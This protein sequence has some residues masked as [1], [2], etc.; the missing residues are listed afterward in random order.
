M[1]S[2]GAR[3]TRRRARAE[4]DSLG[5]V[6]NL[7]RS[8]R[9]ETRQEIQSL[10]GLGRAVVA[11]RVATLIERGLV[12]EGPPGASTGGRAPTTVRM[13]ASAG[14]VL[15]GSLGTTTLGV[16]LAD[17]TGNLLIEHHEPNDATLGAERTLVR[18]TELFDWLLDEH[19]SIREAWAI[20]LAVPG[21]VGPTGGRLG[22]RPTLH[23]MP[24]WADF[25]IVDELSSRYGAPVIVDSEVHFMA[26]GELRAGQGVGRDDLVFVKV[27]T[28]ISAGLCSDGRIHRGAHGYAGDVGHVAVTDDRATICRCGNTGCLEALAGGIALA[29]DGL[30]AAKEGRSEYLADQLASGAGITAAHVGTGAMRGDP[31][32][33][34]LIS[35]SGRLIGETLV[36]LIAG[37][38]PS[39]VVVGGGVAQAG[40]VL[41]AAVREG[42]YRRS[43]S[44][45]TENLTLVRSELGK[46]AGLIGGA[47][48]ALEGLFADDRLETWIDHGTPRLPAA[49]GT[50]RPKRDRRAVDSSRSGGS[51][52]TTR[53]APRLM[54]TGRT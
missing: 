10:A 47:Q 6:L 39:L 35:R 18:L 50:E 2:S 15:V 54:R 49:S 20:A 22:S 7:I 21:L 45:A 8:G 32:S 53:T 41:I 31:V 19:A 14:A 52:A 42:I 13:N 51:I 16:G 43:R 34:E 3:G 38:N 17:L 44:L 36:T 30:A 9:V 25:P 12:V 40:P 28:G 24:G 4:R 46:T 11:D 29:R 5:L 27:G 1:R 23:L 37:Y 48:A 26:L 33:V